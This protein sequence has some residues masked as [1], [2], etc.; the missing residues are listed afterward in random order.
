MLRKTLAFTA[1]LV[2]PLLADAALYDRGNGMIYDD[3]LNITWLQ[4]A[5]YAQT[6]GY[7]RDGR[8]H[9]YHAKEW[10]HNLSYGGYDDWRLASM[11][12]APL[13][14]ND[15]TETMGELGYM[16][17]TSLGN[18]YLANSTVNYTFSDGG[19]GEIKAI[20]NIQPGIYWY[21]ESRDRSC[22]LTQ[23]DPDAGC[24]IESPDFV[25]PDPI[26]YTTEPGWYFRTDY[27]YESTG[28]KSGNL[29]AWA[30]RGG[31]VSQVP[32][33]AAAWLF[34]CAVIG[35]LGIKRKK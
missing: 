5:N 35:L 7:D 20:I 18:T 24:I 14:G 31:D 22:G 32:I 12:S 33:P 9:W 1:A 13:S 21:G 29:Y 4:D 3:V 17:Y 30:V 28:S 11:G 27:G 25:M 8:M 2:S 16:L 34:G 23:G 26:P 19:S 6:S 10:A 15:F